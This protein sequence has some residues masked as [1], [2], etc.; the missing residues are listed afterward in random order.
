MCLMSC[1]VADRGTT[2][3]RGC[4]S[5]TIASIP[6]DG[7][8]PELAGSSRL[9]VCV[10]AL[11]M[12]A[13]AAVSAA[14]IDT[15]SEGRFRV[16]L[17]VRCRVELISVLAPSL[18]AVIRWRTGERVEDP[19]L[20]TLSLPAAPVHVVRIVDATSSVAISGAEADVD[21]GAGLPTSRF[22][23]DRAGEF[24][25]RSNF[26]AWT[27][28]RVSADGYC[29][30]RYRP[31]F[32]RGRE[33][34]IM[35]QMERGDPAQCRLV[36]QVGFGYLGVQTALGIRVSAIVAG[37][38]VDGR[39]EV[40]DVVSAIGGRSVSDTSNLNKDVMWYISSDTLYTLEVERNS[41]RKSFRI[42]PRRLRFP[43]SPE[44]VDRQDR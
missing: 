16:A 28:L 19:S 14:C 36:E 24:V 31:S 21:W 10:S 12:G 6:I 23:S 33:G 43:D 3:T 34:T 38:P 32:E 5:D 41:V 35:L 20:G 1:C 15:D 7:T 29:Y 8:I 18:G 42:S 30:L 11:S 44:L 9:E 13:S 4:A 37:G 2:E 25:V 40:G 26:D 22:V 27:D 17:N 39:L